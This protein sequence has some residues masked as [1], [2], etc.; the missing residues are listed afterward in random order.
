V[1]ISSCLV[2]YGRL[3]RCCPGYDA[4]HRGNVRCG[5]EFNWM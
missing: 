2:R 1:T 4:C 3:D 5:T